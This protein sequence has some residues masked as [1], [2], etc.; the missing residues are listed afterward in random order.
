MKKNQ[1]EYLKKYWFG[2][3]SQ[4]WNQKNQTVPKWKKKKTNRKKPNQ[5]ETKPI[6]KVKKKNPKN[7]IDFSF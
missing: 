2:S 1:L 5:T 4:A 7:N 6:K 3:V